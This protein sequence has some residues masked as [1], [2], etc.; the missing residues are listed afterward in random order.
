VRIYLLDLCR[1]LSKYMPHI[2]RPPPHARTRTPVFAVPQPFPADPDETAW[3]EASLI[4]SAINAANQVESRTNDLMI[5]AASRELPSAG[6]AV[7]HT[8]TDRNTSGSSFAAGSF[9]QR[10]GV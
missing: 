2:C 3:D 4:D 6:N 9:L 10:A 5:R 7:G 1:N 8:V